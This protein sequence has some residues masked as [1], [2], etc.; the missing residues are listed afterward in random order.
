MDN[1]D[2]GATIRGFTAGQRIFGRYTLKKILGRGGMGVVWL[3]RDESLERDLAIKML[4]E[5][6]ATDPAAVRDLK[7]ETNRSQQLSHPHI[8]RIFDFVEGAGLCGITMELVEGGTLTSRRLDQPGEVFP[9]GRLQPWVRQLCEGLDYAHQRAKVVH[10]DLKPANLM[11]TRGDELKIADFG[12]ARSVS[13]SVSRVSNQAGSSGTPLY[14]S[15]QQMMGED[16]AVTDDIYALGA[17]LYELLTGKPPFHTGNILAQVQTKVPVRVNERRR[18]NGLAAEPVPAGWE[19]TIAAC[20]AKEPADRPQSAAEVA[21]KL[22]LAAP[23]TKDAEPTVGAGKTV[24][25]A[26]SSRKSRAPRYMMLAAGLVA[27]VTA[28]WYFGWY[29]PEQQRLAAERVRQ[30]EIARLEAAKST[31]AANQLRTEKEKAAIEARR[32]AEEA[33]AAAKARTEDEQRA[34]AVM[35]VKIDNFTDGSSA[36]LRSAIDAALKAYLAA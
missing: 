24:S 16:P 2:L 33:Q 31:E 4:P 12:I 9:V 19:E 32:K 26:S 15:P 11:L 13:D 8:L 34:Y 6:V 27:A 5:L 1:L 28:G 30:A 3:A 17:T 23:G 7:R 36:S 18:A 20:L 21:Q 35:V 22:G 25:A 14:M 10:R 29:A